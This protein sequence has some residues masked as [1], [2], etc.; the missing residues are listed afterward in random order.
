MDP[1]G[2]PIMGTAVGGAWHGLPTLADGEIGLVCAVAAALYLCLMRAGRALIGLVAVL[3]VCIA[4]PVHI[5]Y[6]FRPAW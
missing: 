3:G 5:A 4:F 2:A 6:I 1:W